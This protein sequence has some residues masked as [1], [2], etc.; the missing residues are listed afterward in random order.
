MFAS[1]WVR[2]WATFHFY[3]TP[4]LTHRKTHIFISCCKHILLIFQ[5][6]TN[7]NKNNIKIKH[8]VQKMH[9]KPHTYRRFI[10]AQEK[11]FRKM[12]LTFAC[13]HIFG[14]HEHTYFSSPFGWIFFF[15]NFYLF[16]FYSV[17]FFQD[18]SPNFFFCSTKMHMHFMLEEKNCWWMLCGAGRGCRIHEFQ[19]SIFQW[20]LQ[21]SLSLFSRMSIHIRTCDGTHLWIILNFPT[22]FPLNCFSKK[23]QQ[24][25]FSNF[26]NFHFCFSENHIMLIT[27][28]F[29]STKR[30][31]KCNKNLQEWQ[32]QRN[33]RLH[34]TYIDGGA[35]SYALF[36]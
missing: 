16:I 5:R 10:F 11:F 14:Q 15:G 18:F 9:K 35:S 17:S 3:P 4:P 21:G 29:E 1:Y 2:S 23:Q 8:N 22:N 30:R 7:N 31:L 36:H 19:C 12:Y 34:H 13:A 33:D 25:K 28:T 24:K 27:H 6:K 26:H 20:I 32:I